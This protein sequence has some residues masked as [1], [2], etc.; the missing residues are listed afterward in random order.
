MRE[1]G[2][3]CLHPEPSLR[4]IREADGV[5]LAL[6]ILRKGAAFYPDGQEDGTKGLLEKEEEGGERKMREGT[7]R[8]RTKPA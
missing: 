2:S 1:F 3:K 7:M 4:R 5:N 6:R 8:P